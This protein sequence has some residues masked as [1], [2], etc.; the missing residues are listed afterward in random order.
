VTCT[1]CGAPEWHMAIRTPDGRTLTP[2]CPRPTAREAAKDLLVLM[3]HEGA[4]Q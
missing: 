4:V 2:Q 1:Y 3:Q